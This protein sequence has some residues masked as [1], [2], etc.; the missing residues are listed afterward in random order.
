VA[1]I[2]KDPMSSLN[3]IPG[4]LKTVSVTKLIPGDVS[5]SVIFVG[6]SV[7]FD[8]NRRVLLR[9]NRFMCYAGGRRTIGLSGSSMSANC[10][11]RKGCR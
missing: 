7:V 9:D 1:L 11:I 5:R 10:M 3:P 2:P 4:Q 8:R 6:N